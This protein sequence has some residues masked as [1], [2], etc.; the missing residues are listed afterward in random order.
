M[1]MQ[2]EETVACQRLSVLELAQ[3]LGNVSEACRSSEP[4]FGSRFYKSVGELQADLDAWLAHYNAGRPHQ[5]YRNMGRRPQDEA[6]EVV[7]DDG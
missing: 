7:R 3:A 1:S 5:G 4:L 2:D 6:R